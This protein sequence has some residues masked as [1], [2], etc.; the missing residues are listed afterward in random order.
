M[1]RQHLQNKTGILY[2]KF[3]CIIRLMEIFEN[4]HEIRK[5]EVLQVATSKTIVNIND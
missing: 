2:K 5:T 3:Q 4:E 1:T